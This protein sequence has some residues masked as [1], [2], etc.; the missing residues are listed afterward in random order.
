MSATGSNSYR[1]AV[2]WMKKFER[3]NGPQ[4]TNVGQLLLEQQ[5]TQRTHGRDNHKK[6]SEHDV[7]QPVWNFSIELGIVTLKPSGGD[8]VR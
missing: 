5:G 1:N 3:K 2:S 4:T 8:P 6:S 7:R